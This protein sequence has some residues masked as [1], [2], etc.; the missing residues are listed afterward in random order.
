VDPRTLE[1]DKALELLA[2][3]AARLEKRSA[4]HKSTKP[5]AKPPAKP[6]LLAWLQEAPA[7]L[8]LVPEFDP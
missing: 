3:K 6:G 8:V 7:P 4:A 1:L 5:K 2:A